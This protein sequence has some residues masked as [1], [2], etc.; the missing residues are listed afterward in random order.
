L[1]GLRARIGQ[2][3]GGRIIAVLEAR[4]NTMKLGVHRNSLAPSLAAA[5]QAWFLNSPDL[6]WDLPGAVAALGAKAHFAADVETLAQGISEYAAPGD[7]I[8]VMSNGGFG[9][10]HDK[11]LAALRARA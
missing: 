11:L 6:G 10:L 4:S 1:R 5:D 3:G 7:H 8:V 2:A 9:G